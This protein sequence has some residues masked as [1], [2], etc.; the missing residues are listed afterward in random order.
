[1]QEIELS[2]N[3]TQITTEIKTYQSIG[4]QAIFEIGRRLKWVKEN[5]LVHGEFGKWLE[6]INMNH[7]TANQFMKIAK[8]LSNSDTYQNLGSNALYLIAT[9]P[10][11]EREKPHQLDSGETKKLDEMTVR[12]LQETK[13][14]LNE[15]ASQLRQQSETIKLQSK[16]ID[17]LNEKEPLIVEKPV[18]VIPSDYEDLKVT[19][20]NLNKQLSSIRNDLKMKQMQYD[21]L[22]RNTANAQALEA[23]IEALRKQEKSIDERIKATFEFNDLLSE[24]NA[25]FDTKMASLRF[26][27]LVNEL[28]DTE[29]ANKLQDTVNSIDFW[30]SEMRK[31]L[32]NGKKIIEGEIING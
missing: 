27:P 7:S 20:E 13:K 24:I 3:L 30:V 10:E 14:K 19:N 23:N 22:E 4:G 12:E 26:K 18:E 28:Y 29:A 25:F 2:N 8:E 1:M 31:I 32:P 9:M 17:D 6:S 16:M 15:Q 5:N 11:E 21:L